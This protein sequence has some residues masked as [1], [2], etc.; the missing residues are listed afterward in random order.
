MP[1]RTKLSFFSNDSI[2]K[3][4]QQGEITITNSGAT[5]DYQAAL[6]VSD[7]VTNAYGRAGFV[8]ARWSIDGGTNW[9]A[10]EAELIYTFT[11]NSEA[12]DP[13]HPTSFLLN[14]LDSAVSIGC[15]DSTITFRTAN[16]RHGTVTG[17]VTPSYTPTSRTFVIQWALYER[18]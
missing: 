12:G 5:S 10:L 7:S 6:V 18:E 15:T 2:D 17:F 16:G 9:Q 14:G 8:R 3:V 13:G 11:V 1:D 4:V